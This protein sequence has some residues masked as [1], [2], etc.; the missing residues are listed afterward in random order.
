[1]KLS[2][3][4]GFLSSWRTTS[5][6]VIVFCSSYL[7]F[8]SSGNPYERWIDFLYRNPVG[9][10]IY[11]AFILNI[12]LT[13]IMAAY[14]KLKP[15][16]P[17]PEAIKEMDAWTELPAGEN[18][19]EKAV[20]FAKKIGFRTEAAD[21]RL[22]AVKGRLSFVP[23]AV[24]RSGLIVFMA[25]LFISFHLRKAEET[26]IHEGQSV[27]GKDI[28]LKEINSDLPPGFLRMGEK[29]SFGLYSL[30]GTLSSSK[31][32]YTVSTGLPERVE[33]LYL[34]I[35]HLGFFQPVSIDTPSG[36]FKYGLD[37]DVLPPEK[38]QSVKL[39]S[40][41]TL[42]FKLS[43][44]K[45]VKKGLLTGSMFNFKRPLYGI[46]IK[47]DNIYLDLTARAGGSASGGG[48]G[49]SPG[50][51]SL[52]IK[53]ESVYDPSVLWIYAGALLTLTGLGLM[54]IRPFWYERRICA[55]EVEGR[56][57]IGY[58][59]EFYKKWG[60]RRFERLRGEYSSG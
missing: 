21:G 23:G 25:A 50:D 29:G 47:K 20:E 27:G 52:F 24:M 32:I 18:P 34:R 33:G 54:S 11:W 39:P 56:A 13:N 26:V 46:S 43:P 38:T 6:L 14:G 30:S 22:Y 37:L 59:E 3:A 51:N 60:I 45:T 48:Y 55:L 1:V 17:T 9:I 31:G 5:A 40:G 53:I 58:S 10:A 49:I 28:Y 8:T 15:L 16:R 57:L 36:R 35:I 44:D 19:M 41:E 7:Y 12:T 2:K 4:I 42:T